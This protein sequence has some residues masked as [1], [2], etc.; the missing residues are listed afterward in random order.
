[1]RDRGWAPRRRPLPRK[2]FPL[3]ARCAAACALTAGAAKTESLASLSPLKRS[4]KGCQSLGGRLWQGWGQNLF[5]PER[6]HSSRVG[7]RA[8]CLEGGGVYTSSNPPPPP[9]VFLNFLFGI[10]SEADV[11]TATTTASAA[12]T[13]ADVGPLVTGPVAALLLGRC[14]GRIRLFLPLRC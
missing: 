1:M 6:G 8:K 11:E 10:W 9:Q 3:V 5:C 13:T 7:L 2:H 14:R 4:Q 12:P